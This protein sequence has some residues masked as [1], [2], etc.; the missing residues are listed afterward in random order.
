MYTPEGKKVT[1][2]LWEETLKELEFAG[3]RD[4]L[5]SMGREA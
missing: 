2:G 5:E 3:V 4:I 1:D